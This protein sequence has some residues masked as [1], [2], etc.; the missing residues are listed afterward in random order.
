MALIQRLSF[1]LAFATFAA[2]MMLIAIALS[3][4][5]V[6]PQRRIM[7]IDTMLSIGKRAY[8]NYF[9]Y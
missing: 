7:P 6:Q 8:W 9:A 2:S 1:V 3:F 5:D 4:L